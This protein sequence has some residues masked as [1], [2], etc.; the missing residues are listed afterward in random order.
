MQLDNTYT[1]ENTCKFSQTLSKYSVKTY[2][3]DPSKV[4]T[5]KF[6][7]YMKTSQCNTEHGFNK[8]HTEMLYN[9]SKIGEY[10]SSQQLSSYCHFSLTA[11]RILSETS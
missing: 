2:V 10:S 3:C 4:F 6:N 5:D 8:M 11:F 7:Y 9:V 1:K